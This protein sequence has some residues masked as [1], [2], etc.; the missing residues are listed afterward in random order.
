M[1]LSLVRADL[2]QASRIVRPNLDSLAQLR[3]AA[4]SMQE[5]VADLAADMAAAWVLVLVAPAA[6]VAVKSMSPTFVTSSLVRL[7]FLGGRRVNLRN[8]ASIYC[9]MAGSEGPVPPS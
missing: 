7:P 9:G 3:A 1:A 2:T 4:A 6:V 5:A 8:L